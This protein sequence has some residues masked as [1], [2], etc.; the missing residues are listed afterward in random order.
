V[1]EAHTFRRFVGVKVV[2]MAED[3]LLWEISSFAFA[4]CLIQSTAIPRFADQIAANAFSRCQQLHEVTFSLVDTVGP[5]GTHAVLEHEI[6]VSP[7]RLPGCVTV[8]DGSIFKEIGMQA[9]SRSPLDDFALPDRV[10]AIGDGAFQINGLLNA[11]HISE[12]AGLRAV[13]VRTFAQSSLKQIYIPSFLRAIP[14]SCFADSN[15]LTDLLIT[16]CWQL[17]LIAKDAF[18]DCKIRIITVAWP[19][20][21]TQLY[22]KEMQLDP[23]A[24]TAMRFAADH[25]RL[26]WAITRIGDGP[27]RY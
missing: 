2:Q 5:G 1:I 7:K 21:D 17:A 20:W 22:H 12:R 10:Q 8:A 25:V 14:D 19:A 16:T 23:P 3:S 27:L 11:F 15:A 18:A 24:L 26:E 9:F 13:G 4:D 6:H